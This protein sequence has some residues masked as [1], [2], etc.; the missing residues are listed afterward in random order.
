[1]RVDHL[2][3]VPAKV[4]GRKGVAVRISRVGEEEAI[5]GAYAAAVRRRSVLDVSGDVPGKVQ[6]KVRGNVLENV[7]ENVRENV[8]GTLK[9]LQR[10]AVRATDHVALHASPH[11]H[12][13]AKDTFGL[14][15][16]HRGRF[17]RKLPLFRRG[18]DGELD[19]TAVT[20]LV[21]A[22]PELEIT[23]KRRLRS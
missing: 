2:T 13:K 20:R 6:E 14:A 9:G 10:S 18:V 1:M 7:R 22:F 21:K 19:L 15:P 4:V 3:K 16:R 17:V 11:V 12:S 23:W 5:R 8:Q